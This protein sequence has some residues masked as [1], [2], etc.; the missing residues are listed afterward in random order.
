MCVT[1]KWL[2]VAR[3][4]EL[5]GETKPAVYQRRYSGKWL[6]G[7]QCQIRDRNLWVNLPEAQKWVESRES[8]YP[9]GSKSR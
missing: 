4:C 9:K 6:D 7:V 5:T 8:P 2:K 3:Y 1:L